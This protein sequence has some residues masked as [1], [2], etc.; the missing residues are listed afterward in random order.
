MR[1]FAAGLSLLLLGATAAPA[2]TPA[3]AADGAR[4]ERCLQRV[5]N[6]PEKA[7]DRAVTWEGLGG[8]N[9]ARH[10]AAAALRALGAHQEAAWRLAELGRTLDAPAGARARLLGQAAD[11]WLAAGK[12][13]R[14]RETASAAIEL[15]P[16]DPGLRVTRALIRAQKGAYWAV[17]DD[18]NAALEADPEHVEALVLRATAYR[19]LDT[20][21]LARTDLARA[22]EIDP[23]DPGALLEK[24][25]LERLAGNKDKARAAWLRLLRA[26][27]DDPA[28]A[29]ARRNLQ[30][31]DS[32]VAEQDDG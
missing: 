1:L 9:A 12:L 28:A 25:I 21:G 18:L 16:D 8:G 4:Y 5:E 22:L 26:H 11:S 27:P 3:P 10:C 15:K 31:M 6:D 20:L 23:D 32:G 2:G 29:T 30:R 19:Y 24:G 17:V 13:K 14:A 7:F